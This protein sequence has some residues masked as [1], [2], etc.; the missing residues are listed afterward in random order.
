[1]FIDLLFKH[2]AQLS[3]DVPT[4]RA[5]LAQVNDPTNLSLIQSLFLASAVYELRPGVVLDLGTGMGNSSTIFGLIANRVG[6]SVH[7]FDLFPTWPEVMERLQDPFRSI[8]AANVTAH[9]DIT[10]YDFKALLGDTPSVL[11][12]WDAHGLT[13]AQHVLSTIMP[14]VA[15]RRHFVLCHDMSD[16]RYVDLKSYDGQPIWG[17]TPESQS[18]FNISWV[19]SRVAQAIPILDFCWRNDLLFHSIDE[20]L[21][22]RTDAQQRKNFLEAVGLPENSGAYMG[23]FTMMETASRNFPGRISDGSTT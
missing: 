6:A 18:Y 7:T 20:E 21:R 22:G 10:A 5:A 14:I 19:C 4:F 13:V 1:M 8:V 11:I 23:Y 16:N 12:F 9:G 17:A 15:D 2:Q 3:A